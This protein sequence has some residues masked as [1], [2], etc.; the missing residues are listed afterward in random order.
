MKPRYSKSD[1]SKAVPSSYVIEINYLAFFSR[2][3]SL[4]LHEIKNRLVPK[5][6]AF[7]QMPYLICD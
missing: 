3:R 7:S 1:P 2:N 6:D 4:L 5:H